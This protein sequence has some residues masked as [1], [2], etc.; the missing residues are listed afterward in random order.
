[1]LCFLFY[2]DLRIDKSDPY[3]YYESRKIDGDQATKIRISVIFQSGSYT[4]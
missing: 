1:M 4:L 3:F 2:R